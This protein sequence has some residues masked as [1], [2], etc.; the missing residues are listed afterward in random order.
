[1]L[2]LL[3]IGLVLLPCDVY[4]GFF[5]AQFRPGR[6][7]AT[8]SESAPTGTVIGTA[9]AE[10][11]N[12]SSMYILEGDTDVIHYDNT[13][14]NI[15]TK[16]AVGE[17]RG[18]TLQLKGKCN[19][20]IPTLVYTITLDGVIQVEV[21]DENDPPVFLNLPHTISVPE[22]TTAGSIV[23]VVDAANPTDVDPFFN[24]EIYSIVN[25]T[26]VDRSV[27]L[28]NVFLIDTL[29]RVRLVNPLD[30][31]E[32]HR[33]LHIALQVKDHGNPPLTAESYLHIFV[34]D[35]DDQTPKFQHKVYTASVIGEK[36]V[37]EECHP[38][39]PA[40]FAED[41]DPVKKSLVRYSIRDGLD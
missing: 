31:E 5:C 28:D 15:V 11:N 26:A 25:V 29:G 14:G 41:Q 30:Y 3:I 18:Q 6:F 7:R 39:R 8:V 23:Y 36:P 12:N 20:Y 17:F 35:S 27:T 34:N 16:K 21:E 10:S 1:M 9:I 24:I 37:I 33:Q 32:G 4:C 13:T 38:T 2:F 22:A 19:E 40:L